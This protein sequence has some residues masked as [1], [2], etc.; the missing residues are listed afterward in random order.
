MALQQ[1]KVVFM[2]GMVVI[3][4]AMTADHI[5]AALSS[6]SAIY[7]PQLLLLY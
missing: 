1:Y 2:F 5:L 7:H 6:S 3:I 4:L